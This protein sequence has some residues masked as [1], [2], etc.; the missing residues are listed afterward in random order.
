MIIYLFILL[1]LFLLFTSRTTTVFGFGS[2]VLKSSASPMQIRP[3]FFTP[4][5][6]SLQKPHLCSGVF[7]L[8]RP[9]SS[10]GSPVYC[11]YR[12]DRES[13][14]NISRA[15]LS[16]S[17]NSFITWGPYRM[18]GLFLRSSFC[19]KVKE[20]GNILDD[21]PRH[22]IDVF[23][24]LYWIKINLLNK[25]LFYHLFWKGKDSALREY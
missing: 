25:Y 14:D 17:R 24:T 21:V 4:P 8:F 5:P 16:Q 15:P 3:T 9:P 13:R 11:V 20:D 18:N 2:H 22:R 23:C 1:G 7:G 12:N 10:L 19:Q 6:P